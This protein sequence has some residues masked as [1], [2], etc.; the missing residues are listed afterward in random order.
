[1]LS[2]LQEIVRYRSLLR[3]LVA[4][5]LKVRYRRS[6]LGVLWTMMNPLLMM[7][8]FTVVFAHFLRFHIE[9]FTIYFLSAYLLWNFF[10]QTTAWSTGCFLGAAPLLRKIYL[11]KS[12]FVIATVLSGLVN[13]FISLAALA[14]IMLV[15]GHP[16]TINLAFLP[17]AMLLATLFALGMS[18]FLAPLCILFADMRQLYQVLLTAWMYLTPIFYPVDII[19]ERWRGIVQAN[20]MRYFVHVFR[21]PI[22]A[23]TLPEPSVVLGAAAW[24]VAMLLT[25]W[26]VF[27]HYTD[28]IAYYL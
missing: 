12:V 18:L 8:V 5:D 27:E 6:F 7:V 11:P 16:F 9:H 20:P 21:E 14:I 3:D 28:R 26:L 13:L 15:V 1:M 23:G 24:G 19:P 17:V 22:Y 25:G 2:S 10:A 4:R